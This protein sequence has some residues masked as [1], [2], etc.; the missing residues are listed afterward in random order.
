MT[1][2]DTAPTESPRNQQRRLRGTRPFGSKRELL[3]WLERQGTHLG[4]GSK[5]HELKVRLSMSRPHLWPDPAADHEE[6]SR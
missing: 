1:P 6:I 3:E 2:T 5:R 4:S